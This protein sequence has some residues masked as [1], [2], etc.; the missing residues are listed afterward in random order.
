MTSL[1]HRPAAFEIRGPRTVETSATAGA[2]LRLL[3]SEDGWSL[4]GID[5][6]LVFHALGTHGRGSCL[7]FARANGVLAVFS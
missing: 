3:P 7:E 4:V 6:A 2:C 1:A 5:G